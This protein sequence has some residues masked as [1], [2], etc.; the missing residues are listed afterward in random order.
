MLTPPVWSLATQAE[1]AV[2]DSTIPQICDCKTPSAQQK[3]DVVRPGA[4]EDQRRKRKAKDHPPKRPS[5]A[6]N[7]ADFD[8]VRLRVQRV[9]ALHAHTMPSANRTKNNMSN[10]SPKVMFE[11]L[12]PR[13]VLPH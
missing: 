8:V 7:E 5:A 2:K 10:C 12:T 13:I 6:L 4:K 11:F 1:W 3:T 9:I